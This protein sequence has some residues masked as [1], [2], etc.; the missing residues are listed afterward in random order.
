M[1]KDVNLER[2]KE[3][4]WI[5]LYYSKKRQLLSN[6]IFRSWSKIIISRRFQYQTY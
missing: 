5:Q 4:S 6:Q 2:A 3:I 1:I